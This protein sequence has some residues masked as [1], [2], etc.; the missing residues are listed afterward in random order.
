MALLGGDGF[1]AYA[2][3]WIG[4]GDT[5]KPGSSGFSYTENEYIDALDAFVEASD[6]KKPFALVVQ[7]SLAADLGQ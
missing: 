5:D 7:V 4:H 2:P 1:T 3:D 6:I